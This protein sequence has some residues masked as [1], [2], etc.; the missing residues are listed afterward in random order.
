MFVLP[1]NDPTLFALIDPAVVSVCH[2]DG[3]VTH[4]LARNISFPANEAGQPLSFLLH[5]LA[6]A[7]LETLFSSC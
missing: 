5:R 7:S 6:G 2:D 1:R 3:L 4:A